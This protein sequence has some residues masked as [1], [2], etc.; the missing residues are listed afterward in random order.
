MQLGLRRPTKAKEVLVLEIFQLCMRCRRR[1]AVL[2]VV[3]DMMKL[4][5]MTSYDLEQQQQ[6]PPQQFVIRIC[7]RLRLILP[8]LL[9]LLL[10]LLLRHCPWCLLVQKQLQSHCDCYARTIPSP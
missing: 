5:G 10:L 8:P 7:C 6:Q 2:V 1:L 4:I 3:M 9:L